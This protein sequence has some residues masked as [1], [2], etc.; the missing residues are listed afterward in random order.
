MLV[1]YILEY[2][3][4]LYLKGSMRPGTPMDMRTATLTGSSGSVSGVKRRSRP[5]SNSQA[6]ITSRLPQPAA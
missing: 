1:S 5:L 3:W 2:L 6:R 4:P